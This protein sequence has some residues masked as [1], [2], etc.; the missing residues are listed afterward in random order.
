VDVGLK[1]EPNLY[2]NNK[3]HTELRCHSD[4]ESQAKHQIS[5]MLSRQSSIINETIVFLLPPTPQEIEI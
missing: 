2:Q 5:T 3:V 1:V 4:S